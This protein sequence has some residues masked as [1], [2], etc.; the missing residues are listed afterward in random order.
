MKKVTENGLI[1]LG[2]LINGVGNRVNV[3]EFGSY[4]VFALNDKDEECAKLGCG[5]VSDLANAFESQIA[6]YLADFVPPL[7]K[8]LMDAS[9]ERSTKLSAIV[10]LGD[11]AMQAGSTFS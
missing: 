10:A 11:L 5:I 3:T 6:S 9:H 4:V 7:I 2:G 8:I 1:A